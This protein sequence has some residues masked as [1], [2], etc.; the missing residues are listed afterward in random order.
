[1][2]EN[3]ELARADAEK[4]QF[5]LFSLIP[6]ELQ[7][8][9]NELAL[10][11]SQHRGNPLSKLHDLY[12]FTDE[13]LKYVNKVT[14]CKKGCDY[15]C[16]IPVSV[17]LL[18]LEYMKKHVKKLRS[19]LGPANLDTNSPCPL[20]NNGA[21]SVYELRPFHCRK[22]VALTSTSYW[23]HPDRCHSVKLPLFNMTELTKVYG[24]L[25]L[26]AGPLSRVIDIRNMRKAL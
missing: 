15:C 18:E 26:E 13:L 7:K 24:Q 2:V 10:S 4:N 3:I 19:K 20:L 17:S 21:C 12:C 1:M 5:K 6:R 16:N 22:H 9:E 11:F 23:C 14:P 8:K 25:L